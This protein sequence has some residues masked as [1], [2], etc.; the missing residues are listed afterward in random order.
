LQCRYR[1]KANLYRRPVFLA[2]DNVVER[3]ESIDQATTYLMA[4]YNQGSIVIVAARSLGQ[5][6]GLGISE[7]ECLELPELE[8][9]EARSLFLDQFRLIPETIDDDDEE[10][11]MRCVK[12]CRFR[13]GGSA[14]HQFVPLALEVLGKQ[15]WYLL[16]FNPR[17]WAVELQQIDT[18]NPIRQNEHPLFSIL[19]WS[20]DA[21]Q[22][23]PDQLIFMDAALFF[24]RFIN[25]WSGLVPKWSILDRLSLVLRIIVDAVKFLVSS[26]RS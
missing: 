5:L 21:L 10:L 11:L 26:V 23:E 17:Q 22:R 2:I 14:D 18:F 20:Y 19:R 3:V 7:S 9:D 1:L 12:R 15:L 16:G 25:D 4:G 13:K 24:P 6:T 8:E